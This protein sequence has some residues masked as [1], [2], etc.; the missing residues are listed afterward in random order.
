MT[1]I[2]LEL[3]E[4]VATKAKEAGLLTPEGLAGMVDDALIRLEAGERI[5]AAADR[6]SQAEGPVMSEEEVV[7]MVK[8]MRRAT[9]GK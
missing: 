9:D 2:T 8:E 3:P 7:A 5:L 1:T 6:V 4:D